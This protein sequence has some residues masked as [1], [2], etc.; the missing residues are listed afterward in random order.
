MLF[1]SLEFLVFF[2][3]VFVLFAR[4]PRARIFV[5]L[6]ASYAFYMNWQVEYILL[7]ITST[8]IDYWAAIKIHA[9]QGLRKK[10]FLGISLA[11]NLSILF[12]FKYFNFFSSSL[13]TLASAFGHAYQ[14]FLT[15]VLLPVGISFYTFQ[16]L[17]YS[18]D[19]YR[20]HIKP[21][22]SLPTFA[23]FVSF[24]PQLIAGPIE[25]AG[26][27][28]NQLKNNLC[29]STPNIV[30]GCRFILWGLFKKVVIAD[31]L[32]LLVD[33]VFKAPESY[34]AVVTLIA[35]IGFAFQIYCD[36]AGY[37]YM[38]IGLARVFGIHLMTNFKAPYFSKSVRE[39]WGRW[40]IS[41]STWF[42]DYLYIPLGGNRVAIW[43][44]YRNLF[45]TFI[46]SGLWHGANWT[47]IVWGG[48]HGTFLILEY[49]ISRKWRIQQPS[50][51][52]ALFK[53]ALTFFVV[54]IAWIFFRADSIDHSLI[55]F[56]NFSNISFS[57]TEIKD[58]LILTGIGE[59]NLF[60]VFFSIIILLLVD[61]FMDI[62]VIS[63]KP[64]VRFIYYHVLF[65]AILIFGITDTNA[66]IYFQF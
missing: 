46:I 63:S 25:R 24:F 66:F 64:W 58:Q 41:L 39:F 62:T 44:W 33:P 4:I 11:S 54:C 5:L 8:I 65:F 55:L 35:A 23:L 49:I 3:L 60:I 37:S 43:K 14:P 15:D 45:I 50:R 2:L 12:F 29:L 7:I 48:I 27:L 51:F 22:K 10:I 18:I 38:A 34:G 57:V 53:W 1:N 61:R 19:V 13:K 47:F 52:L 59:L 6:V 36:F 42:R 40:H 26:S 21:E 20:G 30:V 17:S 31:R 16:T 32:A 56:Q 28:I 9:T